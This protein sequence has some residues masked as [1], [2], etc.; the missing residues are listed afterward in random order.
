MDITYCKNTG[1][2]YRFSC[3]RFIDNHNLKGVNWISIAEFTLEPNY[4]CKYYMEW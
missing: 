3:K 2:P 1:C 4:T